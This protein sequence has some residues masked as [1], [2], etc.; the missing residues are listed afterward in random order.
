MDNPINKIP[1]YREEV[2]KALPKLIV[3]DNTYKDGEMYY[4]EDSKNCFDLFEI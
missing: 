2:F 4:S 3:L 1:N